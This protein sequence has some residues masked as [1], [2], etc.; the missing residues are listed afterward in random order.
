[1]ERS[2][3]SNFFISGQSDSPAGGDKTRGSQGGIDFWFLKVSSTGSK[4]W[5]KRF[6]GSLNDELRASV[7]TSDGGYL[8][9]GKS[10]SGESGNKTQAS[11]GSSDYW[12]VKTKSL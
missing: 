2:G 9:A 4:I 5:D 8:L 1:M 3:S 11:Q 12:I 7:Q 10:F 6:G